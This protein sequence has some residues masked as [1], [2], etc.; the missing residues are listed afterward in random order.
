MAISSCLASCQD[1]RQKTRKATSSATT[2]NKTIA[3]TPTLV[4][5]YNENR[6]Y[7]TIRNKSG[8]VDLLYAYSSADLTSNGFLLK[9]GESTDLESVQTLYAKSATVGQ[10]VA[11]CVD[12]GM[13]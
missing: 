2:Y 3:D 11:I 7:I 8:S 1:S 13:G 4:S 5:D 6:T 10:T 12:E 9:F